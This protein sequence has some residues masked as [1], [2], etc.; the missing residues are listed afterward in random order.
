M[1]HFLD[2][3]DSMSSKR[4]NLPVLVFLINLIT[5]VNLIY[6]YICVTE[7]ASVIS[8]IMCFICPSFFKHVRGKILASRLSKKKQHKNKHCKIWTA[9]ID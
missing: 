6:V 5:R 1:N 2:N 7:T 8:L 4:L 3:D 9:V